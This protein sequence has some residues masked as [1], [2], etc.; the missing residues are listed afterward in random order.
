MAK[1]MKRSRLKPTDEEEVL[2]CAYSGLKSGANASKP[3]EAGSRRPWWLRGL[4]CFIIL[5]AATTT[6]EDDAQRAKD[7]I[8]VRA[9]LRLPGVDFSAKPEAKAALLRHLKTV[10]GS[11]QYLELVEKFKLREASE[12]LLRLAVE[13]SDSTLGVKAAG[14]LLKLDERELL[15]KAIADQDAA[16]AAKMVTVLGLLAD[17]KTNGLIEPLITSGEP[18]LPIRAAAVTAL[19]GSAPGQQ[20]ML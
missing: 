13:Q 5:F 18:P 20:R 10:K 12:E 15:R 3:A 14:L 9:L 16:K 4:V 6:A 17:A 7:A 8:I 1:A 11:E 19:G 2:V